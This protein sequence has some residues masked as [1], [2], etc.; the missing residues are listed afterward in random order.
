MEKKE[1]T[2]MGYTGIIGH[3]TMNI[4]T[5]GMVIS[6]DHMEALRR[7]CPSL[8]LPSFVQTPKKP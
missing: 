5:Q 6:G 1:T 4:I 8:L 7:L 3:I 2:I